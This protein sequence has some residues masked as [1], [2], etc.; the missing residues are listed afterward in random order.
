MASSA[1]EVDIRTLIA[2]SSSSATD[3]FDEGGKGR[4]IERPAPT[5]FVENG[6]KEAERLRPDFVLTEVAF[7]ECGDESVPEE[8]ISRRFGIPTAANDSTKGVFNG[9]PRRFLKVVEG[10]TAQKDADPERSDE[11]SVGTPVGS[12]TC[13]SSNILYV[14]LGYTETARIVSEVRRGLKR[15]DVRRSD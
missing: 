15:S 13:G 1:C 8:K 2:L 6:V 4:G 9:A 10:F 7:S 3:G 5:A 12:M 11:K 14:N